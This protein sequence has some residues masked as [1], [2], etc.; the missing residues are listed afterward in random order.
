MIFA[1]GF[2]LVA[3]GML[4]VGF[5]GGPAPHIHNT[6]DYIGVPVVYIGMIMMVVS[7][8]MAAARWLP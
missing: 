3:I 5:F 4:L 7:L 6:A 2:A 8:C 1:I